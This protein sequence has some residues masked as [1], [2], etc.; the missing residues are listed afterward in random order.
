MDPERESIERRIAEVK[1]SLATR[2][3]MLGGRLNRARRAVAIKDR[4]REHIVPSMG[5]AAALGFLLGRR[6]AR[7]AHVLALPGDIRSLPAPT[8]APVQRKSLIASALEAMV[9]SVAAT[10][11]ATAATGLLKDYADKSAEIQ[12]DEK[13][14][15]RLSEDPFASTERTW[16]HA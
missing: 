12:A 8:P 7:R 5:V 4:L 3:D 2:L 13:V 10:V 14:G 9:R 15:E 11:A 16:P 1:R 6:A